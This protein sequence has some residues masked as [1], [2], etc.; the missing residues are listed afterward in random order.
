MIEK[1]RRYRKI[2]ESLVPS[3]DDE[4]ALTATALFPHW[5]E[6][7]EYAADDRVQY[8]GVLYRCLQ[9]HTAQAAWTP[10]DAVSLWARVLV[11]DPHDIPEW[12]QPSSTNPYM[13]GDKVRHV[14]KVW[15]SLIDGNVWEP[16]AVGTESL[17][18]ERS[19]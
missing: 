15:E 18:A 8:G 13:R 19:E 10:T 1:A 3:L 5:S 7:G 6:S 17:W 11:P 12:V 4:T 2:I 16:G 9:A 14:G